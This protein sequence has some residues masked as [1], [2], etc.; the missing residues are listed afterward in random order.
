MLPLTLLHTLNGPIP[1]LFTGDLAHAAQLVWKNPDH[2]LFSTPL[3]HIDTALAFIS[4]PATLVWRRTATDTLW[5]D[6][7]ESFLS[8]VAP[9]VQISTANVPS[10]SLAEASTLKQTIDLTADD[11]KADDWSLFAPCVPAPPPRN[12]HHP[13]SPRLASPI[14]SI[15]DSVKPVDEQPRPPPIVPVTTRDESSDPPLPLTETLDL[16][17]TASAVQRAEEHPVTTPVE[18]DHGETLVTSPHASN[19]TTR[20]RKHKTNEEDDTCPGKR[21]HA[22]LTQRR[23]PL[24]RKCRYVQ[25]RPTIP[26]PPGERFKRRRQTYHHLSCCRLSP[27]TSTNCQSRPISFNC[28][29]YPDLCSVPPVSPH[30]SLCLALWRP[31][32]PWRLGFH[33]R[34]CRF[35]RNDLT[36]EQSRLVHRSPGLTPAASKS[37]QI[38]K[39]T[40]NDDDRAL[41]APRHPVTPATVPVSPSADHVNN[42]RTPHNDALTHSQ[43]CRAVDTFLKNYNV[44]KTVQKPT[45]AEDD[46]E[47]DTVAQHLDRWLQMTDRQYRS[48]PFCLHHAKIQHATIEPRQSTNAKMNKT[49]LPRHSQQPCKNMPCAHA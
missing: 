45:P 13:F 32:N 21:V 46:R 33:P 38:R 27:A 39:P 18:V 24:S 14:A 42:K 12:P 25:R 17:V 41:F 36:N 4:G 16:S 11:D 34:L 28:S 37:T 48:H 2:P 35:T 5:D 3:T 30:S 43:N 20:K 10:P 9:A 29:L 44:N 31:K 40:T 15:L 49:E 8:V 19:G 22:Q 7:L 23:I 1:I 6:F 26:P 47:Y